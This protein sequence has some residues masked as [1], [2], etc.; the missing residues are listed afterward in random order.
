M[1]APM[2]SFESQFRSIVGGDYDPSQELGAEQARAL[3]A[4]IFSMPESQVSRDGFF[5]EYEG[6]CEDQRVYLA[7]TVTDDHLSGIRAECESLDKFDES[8]NSCF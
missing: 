2:N 4:L 3:S 8:L 1:F 7:V 5:I 6:W